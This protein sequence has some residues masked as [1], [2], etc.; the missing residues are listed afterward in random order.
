MLRTVARMTLATGMIIAGGIASAQVSFDQLPP[1]P[2]ADQAPSGAERGATPKVNIVYLVPSDRVVQQKYVSALDGAVKSL[3]AWYGRQ[4]PQHR[5]FRTASPVV[6]VVPLPHAAAWYADNPRPAL[7]TQFWDN[8]LADAFPLTGGGFN[9]PQNVWAY[10]IDADSACG[11]C[12]G[13]GTS[14][15][16]VIAAN[17][18]R[19]LVG[20]P[21]R[22]AC[23]GDFD[24]G[25]PDRFIGGLGH[26]LG[27]AFGLP[28]PPGCDQGSVQCDHDAL[29][30]N[31]FRAYPY[32]YL[33]ADEI[34]TLVNS[35]FFLLP[36]AKRRAV[37][38]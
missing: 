23:P 35:P 3:Q 22:P 29:M 21:W 1:I 16:L 5:T 38:H 37:R 9:D 28:H 15:V 30:W 8:V 18:L 19:G 17:D 6:H 2:R 12:G 4:I 14:G 27:H 11:Q 26:E 10:Y 25:G 24:P 13:C 31:G 20:E 33:R 32:T 36:P 34:A 7:F